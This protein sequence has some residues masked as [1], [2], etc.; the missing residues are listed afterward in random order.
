MPLFSC[1]EDLYMIN[2][3]S[4]TKLYLKYKANASFGYIYEDD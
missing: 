3:Y 4:K 1:A 2:K